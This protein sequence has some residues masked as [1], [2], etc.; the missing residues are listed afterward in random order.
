MA[1]DKDFL[2]TVEGAVLPLPTVDI[3]GTFQHNAN[4]TT[5][6]SLQKEIRIAL[7]N[8][9]THHFFS[10][11]LTIVVISSIPDPPALIFYTTLLTL[12]CQEQEGQVPTPT[13]QPRTVSDIIADVRAHGHAT[14]LKRLLDLSTD[15]KE[16][17]KRPLPWL[18]PTIAAPGATIQWTSAGNHR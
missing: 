17:G 4:D 8:H 11:G 5:R 3:V 1:S 18:T 6:I 13:Q 16:N 15:D 10:G 2:L 14:W 9:M 7:K 12:L